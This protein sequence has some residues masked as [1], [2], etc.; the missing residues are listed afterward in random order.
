ME[1]PADEPSDMAS[2]PDRQE[3]DGLNNFEIDDEMETMLTNLEDLMFEFEDGCVLDEDDDDEDSQDEFI[4]DDDRRTQSDKE[5]DF[6]GDENY[7]ERDEQQVGEYKADEE[8]VE[9]DENQGE[10]EQQQ[11]W[12]EEPDGYENGEG[13][14]EQELEN[15]GEDE[16]EV[17]GNAEEDGEQHDH[18]DTNTIQLE[19]SDPNFECKN[20]EE[21]GN[22]G[23]SEDENVL[24]IHSEG[25]FENEEVDE[26]VEKRMDECGQK[27][28]QALDQ[29]S[30]S[31]LLSICNSDEPSSTTV[32]K[33]H[34]TS[35]LELSSPNQ[36]TDQ[37]SPRSTSFPINTTNHGEFSLDFAF[38]KLILQKCD[39]YEEKATDDKERVVSSE[40]KA[41]PV[42]VV[43]D[44]SQTDFAV[45]TNFELPMLTMKE[46]DV[47]LDHVSETH[48]ENGECTSSDDD[49]AVDA[50]KQD[51]M[52]NH[53]IDKMM[54]NADG[55]STFNPTIDNEVYDSK[56]KEQI[57]KLLY[58][59]IKNVG[60][61]K[62][63][64]EMLSKKLIDNES[65]E[66][67]VEII[68]YCVEKRK[69]KIRMKKMKK[70]AH[71]LKVTRNNDYLDC[72]KPKTEVEL[73]QAKVS[74]SPESNSVV[75]CDSKATTRRVVVDC[76]TVN[77]ESETIDNDLRSLIKKKR[78]VVE[79]GDGSSS[80][81]KCHKKNCRK[82]H[83]KKKVCQAKNRKKLQRKEEKRLRREQRRRK[84]RML[85]MEKCRLLE[86]LQKSEAG[87]DSNFE[88][89]I[90]RKKKIELENRI[91]EKIALVLGNRDMKQ[92]ATA[93]TVSRGQ[94]DVKNEVNPDNKQHEAS[95]MMSRV[96]EA[97]VKNE[98][99][100]DNK[101]H[102]SLSMRSRRYEAVE[103]NEVKQD[104]ESSS[105]RSREGSLSSEGSRKS[106]SHSSHS[107]PNKTLVKGPAADS[108]SEMYAE[109]FGKK[110][111]TK[112]APNIEA[113]NVKKEV[114]RDD[115]GE[116]FPTFTSIMSQDMKLDSDIPSPPPPPIISRIAE[117]EEK[118]LKHAKKGQ[119]AEKV[120]PPQPVSE[121]APFKK[122]SR[123]PDK[124][125]RS[126]SR[127]PRN[128]WK[129]KSPS[130]SKP[131]AI[132]APR[133]R[134]PS[135]GS[136]RYNRNRPRPADP[137]LTAAASAGRPF[138][139]AWKR[140][141]R[142]R[143]R[144]R[145]RLYSPTRS[146]SSSPSPPPA[147]AARDREFRRKKKEDF[148]EAIRK[149][150]EVQNKPDHVAFHENVFPDTPMSGNEPPA[151]QPYNSMAN[152]FVQNDSFLQVVD[153]RSLVSLDAILSCPVGVLAVP[154]HNKILHPPAQLQM[155][156]PTH[157]MP[158]PY[159]MNVPD[160]SM[161]QYG[162]DAHMTGH[163]T[164]H[165]MPY[166]G[167]EVIPV[168]PTQNTSGHQQV[169]TNFT[170]DNGTINQS[171]GGMVT[172]INENDS[173]LSQA[174]HCHQYAD[175]QQFSN[176]PESHAYFNSLGVGDAN[177]G[178]APSLR[179][180]ASF[181]P[182][183]HP[184]YKVVH[185]PQFPYPIPV[186]YIEPPRP[187]PPVGI[188]PFLQPP[189]SLK[190]M[191]VPPPLPLSEPPPLFHPPL[192]LSP[193]PS[194][195]CGSP[196][197]PLSPSISECGSV[198][199][200]TSSRR[201]VRV[202][203]KNMFDLLKQRLDP[204]DLPAVLE[205]RRSSQ[206][207][208]V[209]DIK[210][211]ISTVRK[212]LSHR[213][214]DSK[215]PDNTSQDQS[216]VSKPDQSSFKTP[217]QA[218]F[219]KFLQSSCKETDQP[220]PP[221][222]PQQK[223]RIQFK[224]PFV[225]N[226]V[227]QKVAPE[228]IKAMQEDD[229]EDEEGEIVESDSRKSE[230]AHNEISDSN[231]KSDDRDV[232]ELDENGCEIETEA[233][234]QKVLD[235]EARMQK[236]M[237]M[238][239]IF[240][241]LSTKISKKDNNIPFLPD[242]KVDCDND[243]LHEKIGEII[244]SEKEID[245]RKVSQKVSSER[246]DKDIDVKN[247]SQKMSSERI[248]ENENDRKKV[249]Q[250]VSGER[251]MS[252]KETD[253]R[254]ESQK[255][256]S[257]KRMPEKQ[258]DVRKES[259]KISSERRISEEDI[260][261]RKV[262]QKVSGERRM[263]EKEIDRRKESQKVSG[264]RRMSEKEIYG[265]KESQ[266]VGS[267]RRISEKEIDRR[268]QSQRE[269]SERKMS[270][271][272][273][274]GRKVSQ[275]VSSERR[276]SENEIDWREV[277]QKVK[278]E[279]MYEKEIEG[280][281]VSKES[282]E[283][284]MSGKKTVEGS[285]N[286]TDVRKIYPKDTVD[287]LKVL[288]SSSSS[289]KD[290]YKTAVGNIS[291]DSK[292]NSPF[293]S[294]ENFHKEHELTKETSPIHKISPEYKGAPLSPVAAELERRGLVDPL[295]APAFFADC[296][297]MLMDIPLS[298]AK[299]PA[300][301]SA[302]TS[303]ELSADQNCKDKLKCQG[304]VVFCKNYKECTKSGKD[305]SIS[306]K[307]RSR[308]SDTP[309]DH[310]DSSN[311]FLHRSG[312]ESKLPD[313]SVVETVKR[314]SI[315]ISS[316]ES[317]IDSESFIL[318]TSI[319]PEKS[320]TLD[321]SKPGT[322]DQ[323]KTMNDRQVDS[324]KNESNKVS[325]EDVLKQLKLE[326]AHAKAVC[327]ASV[328]NSLVKD[329]QELTKENTSL[330]IHNDS[331]QDK[332]RDSNPTSK[333]VDV[334]NS[335]S[336]DTKY[337]GNL[338]KSNNSELGSSS[339]NSLTNFTENS[340][341]ALPINK[342]QLT[343]ELMSE[344]STSNIYP[345]LNPRAKVS[346]MDPRLNRG[347]IVH[348]I[349][350]IEAPTNL[351]L[352]RNVDVPKISRFDPR[353]NRTRNDEVGRIVEMSPTQPIDPGLNRNHHNV[354]LLQTPSSDFKMNCEKKVVVDSNFAKTQIQQPEQL[355]PAKS[356]TEIP[357]KIANFKPNLK[358]L[359][360]RVMNEFDPVILRAFGNAEENVS[361]TE[362][363]EGGCSSSSPAVETS[364]SAIESQPPEKSGSSNFNSCSDIDS[365]ISE[366]ELP[367]EST[368][369]ENRNLKLS[370]T[371]SSN[372]TGV[373]QK[374]EQGHRKP[375]SQSLRDQSEKT[376]SDAELNNKNNPQDKMNEVRDPGKK[377]DK[378]RSSAQDHKKMNCQDSNQTRETDKKQVE[379]RR[380]SL[381]AT[382]NKDRRSSS[383]TVSNKDH[384]SSLQS[385]SNREKPNT[386]S[387]KKDSSVNKVSKPD[388][389]TDRKSQHSSTSGSG[390]S[391][392]TK[393]TSSVSK[394]ES[395]TVPLISNKDKMVSSVQ[396]EAASKSCSDKSASQD[397]TSRVRSEAASKPQLAS[398]SKL[399]KD[400]KRNK[401]EIVDEEHL[402]MLKKRRTSYE[403]VP[404]KS[405]ARKINNT[406]SSDDEA[407]K[408]RRASLE[409]VAER[410]RQKLTMNTSD[411]GKGKLEKKTS[412]LEKSSKSSST[413]S[414]SK[415]SD[416]VNNAG[417]VSGE[418]LDEIRKSKYYEKSSTELSKK[419]VVASLSN[420]ES[421]NME[422][423]KDKERR[424]SVIEISSSDDECVK[425]ASPVSK[426]S[427]H[428]SK[429]SSKKIKYKR[430]DS[431]VSSSNVNSAKS[432]KDH[433]VQK[434]ISFTKGVEEKPISE[435]ELKRLLE[436]DSSDED[437]DFNQAKSKPKDNA[438]RVLENISTK[439]PVVGE[440]NKEIA[441]SRNESE[442]DESMRRISANKSKETLT[443]TKAEQSRMFQDKTTDNYVT[444]QSLVNVTNEKAAG[445]D[446][447]RGKAKKV[448]EKNASNTVEA[449]Q[450]VDGNV[451]PKK[452]DQV[453]KPIKMLGKQAVSTEKPASKSADVK[454][455]N[456]NI[457]EPVE[458]SNVECHVPP[459]KIDQIEKP[460][461]MMVKQAVST[462][463]PATKS[464]DV[465]KK[466]NIN[467]IEPVETS[468]VECHV[469]PEKIDQ[470]KKPIKI[471]GNEAATTKSVTTDAVKKLKTSKEN[472]NVNVEDKKSCTSDVKHIEKL[473]HIPE[474]IDKLEE[475]ENLID[476]TLGL[477]ID[478]SCQS[479]TKM[480]EL[481][482]SNEDFNFE[483][484]SPKEVKGRK[485]NKLDK[486]GKL[487]N[488][489]LK[490]G[491]D[492]FPDQE[493]NESSDSFKNLITNICGTLEEKNEK[494]RA[495]I[496][497]GVK[498]CEDAALVVAESLKIL[499]T[500][501][502]VAECVR[503]ERRRM[504]VLNCEVTDDDQ[505]IHDISDIK[506]S[507]GYKSKPMNKSVRGNRDGFDSNCVVS[508]GD[509]YDV[510]EFSEDLPVTANDRRSLLPSLTEIAQPPHSVALKTKKDK[511]D[512]T[513]Q[514][515][516]TL[517]TSTPTLESDLEI[518]SSRMENT[519]AICD[520][521]IS[522]QV[523]ESSEMG[524]DD[525]EIE[526]A[527]DEI[528]EFVAPDNFD[529]T[530]LQNVDVTENDEPKVISKKR[531]NTFSVQKGEKKRILTEVVDPAYGITKQNIEE[532]GISSDKIVSTR[533]F[534][535][536]EAQN[537]DEVGSSVGN[538][539]NKRLSVHE[540]H[541]V[542]IIESPA[543][544]VLGVRRANENPEQYNNKIDTSS[545]KT[546]STSCGR[547]E[548]N[549]RRPHKTKK[550]FRSKVYRK[551]QARYKAKLNA[552]KVSST[553]KSTKKRKSSPSLD[554]DSKK[555]C[556]TNIFTDNQ[557]LNNEVSIPTGENVVHP[558]DSPV[559]EEASVD[560]A[561]LK[562]K[563]KRVKKHGS[564]IE[565]VCDVPRKK[566]KLKSRV[567][568][569]KAES[570]N[571]IDE[572]ISESE[573]KSI[574]KT[575]T[576]K[577]SKKT[578]DSKRSKDETSSV[579]IDD[580]SQEAE[581]AFTRATRARTSLVSP[582]V[583]DVTSNVLEEDSQET[584][585][586]RVT[587]T[588]KSIGTSLHLH[589]V[590]SSSV[591]EDEGETDSIS[592]AR[593]T[594]SSKRSDV[595][596]LRSDDVEMSSVGLLEEDSQEIEESSSRVTRAR[597]SM[598]TPSRLEEVE[599]N[600]TNDDA[601]EN[602]L[603]DASNEYED[604]EGEGKKEL[605]KNVKTIKLQGEDAISKLTP[606]EDEQLWTRICQGLTYKRSRAVGTNVTS[607]RGRLI[608]FESFESIGKPSEE[609]D[610]DKT[611]ESLVRLKKQR[612][613]QKL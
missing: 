270:E 347:N 24:V 109:T 329:K 502:Q 19:D 154:S 395:K 603:E 300:E 449:V 419:F 393:S 105:M 69:E 215:T 470:V 318:E 338:S 512:A 398:T 16:Q 544:L 330:A 460:I 475:K 159:H 191:S 199:S 48:F 483:N 98:A 335:I 598:G 355:V 372:Q 214:T 193:A 157:M 153:Q 560:N 508:G 82:S 80:K 280:G 493:S 399:H 236:Q 356:H 413:K 380:S 532:I 26:S 574:R 145:D 306:L 397:K 249:S 228:F 164:D 533:C 456:I 536:R 437:I 546:I 267:G 515:I 252:E 37:I 386:S 478:E 40:V 474:S 310:V 189:P 336:L 161:L 525:H 404:S 417:K 308:F 6:G 583:H 540:E 430:S 565:D 469:P 301:I 390:H 566:L 589:E 333:C 441:N 339:K 402:K 95:S 133:R 295:P 7:E 360:L 442:S 305:T 407:N 208:S 600:S 590:G 346:V 204:A 52:F 381:E 350:S 476:E 570:C 556:K 132:V 94:H 113:Q 559:I 489:F 337:E 311:D 520:T 545:D 579:V 462:E 231:N 62:I 180:F 275:K 481:T 169:A 400:E 410:V 554:R 196:P 278:R 611:I 170:V 534:D 555:L 613:S 595:I 292:S 342:E 15:E 54:N 206:S 418:K 599:E 210:D 77:L 46:L 262:S 150:Q 70:K 223:V 49:E 409:A 147:A 155:P 290:E 387:A 601:K 541:E 234:K 101:Q 529:E 92:H 87:V 195:L 307:R 217:D 201:K 293:E 506:K 411:S 137:P 428:S 76:N 500:Y 140:H 562:T 218:L 32:D 299:E 431:C 505:L 99:K 282:D 117:L 366:V 425:K 4:E 588:R 473:S 128:Q 414:E 581:G 35:N 586:S 392:K 51:K 501:V 498:N 577:T 315:R 163:P 291:T 175:T 608:G 517:D 324:D 519:I 288:N 396:N 29:G 591:V 185:H 496:E 279:R 232:I 135:P 129:A 367:V 593:V 612:D 139:P 351:V 468:N 235:R 438:N 89:D 240:H 457:I 465:V 144:S 605:R 202:E 1:E 385:T 420:K 149:W 361:D 530:L 90:E 177:D 503:R 254:K 205:S 331:I 93:T 302:P 265:R 401:V 104:N 197:R 103:K 188:V 97:V 373:S 63:I 492:L 596:S 171:S 273:I 83:C 357:L 467:T 120:V 455:M 382:P 168:Q 172:T 453:E 408:Q 320:P 203:L 17:D 610:L 363:I 238:L 174:A 416:T 21:N 563:K 245:Q 352:D 269:D 47:S 71:L 543:G 55:D 125:V 432:S 251:R 86:A 211:L 511:L 73:V 427:S 499:S 538:V 200:T 312:T 222:P 504:C 448:C 377:D 14:V 178:N 406:Q 371:A 513:T 38:P 3:S 383:E 439:K 22:G 116:L 220:E 539:S 248:S 112:E 91:K 368:E 229:K 118:R 384:R 388:L 348:I 192:P 65:K 298:K 88:S 514:S 271:K 106:S 376:Q 575:E 39:R 362:E 304:Q 283:R 260:D 422:P 569:L 110:T 602:L 78:N 9:V 564:L 259:Q 394:Y 23:L 522:T 509:S 141:S 447:S 138:S 274:D 319:N 102:V 327:R 111:A 28:V 284:E 444:V 345:A 477:G 374:T 179:G 43:Q 31:Q 225:K 50:L 594:R 527:S 156:P 34:S 572:D 369:V 277:Y 68:R 606:N 471:F 528:N 124:K 358:S 127:S 8:D 123:S 451:P 136:D 349:N 495:A 482:L 81:R 463:K 550:G 84:I 41:R 412:S 548:V 2:R 53:K 464:A 230:S 165:A 27:K 285:E 258:F 198:R 379:D 359:T 224:K 313:K 5:A 194:T 107:H 286:E 553:D 239:E 592:S 151:F 516:F 490:V 272:E 66:K 523:T 531:K 423:P 242:A 162:E 244:M 126:R 233:T 59:Q 472:E 57:I 221:K 10:E 443:T 573:V 152:Q 44:F 119:S 261:R 58:K 108:F 12:E 343:Q 323:I 341:T 551:L 30:K 181:P 568:K 75:V 542:E 429:E 375:E 440:S 328:E 226:V 64:E 45:Q 296:G 56:K 166:Q 100:Q 421:T 426:K 487:R 485:T 160:T 389:S 114:I 247:E 131:E 281:K 255:V 96:Y 585:D 79:R 488:K 257:E 537:D 143:S 11:V 268:K 584:V 176:P 263:S 25:E 436:S 461:K 219:R 353:L 558:N 167:H 212:T 405:S 571:T 250:K 597:K 334:Q 33:E 60:E 510:F 243:K 491:N 378:S 450:N 184:P 365:Y 415:R 115:D 326:L 187:V 370:T 186:P 309:I 607:V 454:K 578:A 344:S 435:V 61:N 246:P 264:G 521:T 142:S 207:L 445:N 317:R 582:L 241:G 183:S 67:L 314:A 446:E 253:R 122:K 459:K 173:L 13:E 158:S 322:D 20:Y 466:M 325:R 549:P 576:E 216:S 424:S 518:D 580:D 287:E 567:D 148:E 604:K 134:S 403:S 130:T 321:I 557:E 552:F 85:Q 526:G 340:K 497:S 452:I 190:F 391:A 42:P 213:K 256:S 535:V 480:K 294:L 486:T 72:L 507:K 524:K 316:T 484:D 547:F 587:R 354:E 494:S 561:T 182:P 433:P 303:N 434:K 209:G 121:V 74:Q 458:T 18:G 364:T 36:K 289:S 276:M 146:P 332:S 479:N 266:K 227:T 237:K 609:L 297:K